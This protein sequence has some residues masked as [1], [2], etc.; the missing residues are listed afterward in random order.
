M[1]EYESPKLRRLRFELSDGELDSLLECWGREYGGGSTPSLESS[2]S[3]IATIVEHHGF[4]PDSQVAKMCIAIDGEVDRVEGL[5]LD[6]YRQGV[7]GQSDAACLRTRYAS[8]Q[9]DDRQQLRHVHWMAHAYK[10]TP[11]IR[12]DFERY[13]ERLQSARTFVRLALA[14]SKTARSM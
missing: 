6:L 2:R 3:P 7:D 14:R 4:T 8:W 12:I 1:S 13:T 10:L 11:L 9:P 5:V